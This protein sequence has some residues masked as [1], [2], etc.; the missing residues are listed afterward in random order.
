MPKHRAIT[1]F[2]PMSV[3]EISTGATTRTGSW[4]QFGPVTGKQLAMMVTWSGTSAGQ[5]VWLQAALTTNSTALRNMIQRKSSQ[6]SLFAF[7][8]SSG[9]ITHVR[10]KSTVIKANGSV[11]AQITAV[12]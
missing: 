5:S 9:P 7:G 8:T 4:K 3:T 11:T 2:G 12:V 10:L 6:K 1:G